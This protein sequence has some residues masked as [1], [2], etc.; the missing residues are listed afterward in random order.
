MLNQEWAADSLDF[1]VREMVSRE[2]AAIAQL[3][4]CREIAMPELKPGQVLLRLAGVSMD[5]STMEGLR[6]FH[7]EAG[8]DEV[9]MSSPCTAVVVGKHKHSTHDLDVAEG[10]MVQATLQWRRYL[11][12]YPK[13]KRRLM[14]LVQPPNPNP[15]PNHYIKSL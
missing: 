4:Q 6:S 9:V 14:S 10:D 12:V 11:A 2:G 5:R 1:S 3:F 8:S 13:S 15:N 7:P